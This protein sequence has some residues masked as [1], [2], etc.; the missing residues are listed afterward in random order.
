ML[1]VGTGEL[2]VVLAVAMVVLGPDRLPAA[3]RT[4]G[5]AIQHLRQLGADAQHELQRSLNDLTSGETGD[6][7]NAGI[8]TSSKPTDADAA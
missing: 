1:N 3:A 5:R 8:S 2:L 7:G 6:T 4:A